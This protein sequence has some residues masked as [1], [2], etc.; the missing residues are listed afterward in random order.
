MKTPQ[1]SKT[2]KQKLSKPKRSVAKVI[3]SVKQVVKIAHISDEE[4]IWRWGH[5]ERPFLLD[6]QNQIFRVGIWNVWKQSGGDQFEE[7]FTSF[8]SRL[9]VVICQE[10]LL[11]DMALRLFA[12]NGFEA[13]H[14]GTYRR[15]DGC[16]D[17]VLTMA[18]VAAIGNVHRVLSKT[19]EPLLK[20]TK[21]A[22]VSFYP[23]QAG[24]APLA[25]V[26]LHATLIRS[27]KSAGNEVRRI[28]ESIEFHEGPV[29]FAGDFNTFSERYLDEMSKALAAIGCHH[30]VIENDPRVKLARLDQVFIKNLDLKSVS[31]DVMTKHSDH[32]PIVCEFKLRISG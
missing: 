9:D 22:L 13:I 8:A 27:P 23:V 3:A 26:N 28:I 7:E 6:N 1:I 30:V 5:A 20:T 21:A 4:A 15:L 31:I 25:V 29:I 19:P 14:A 2:K 17:G 18:K 24:G 10:A 32:F 12:Q 11:T 16:R